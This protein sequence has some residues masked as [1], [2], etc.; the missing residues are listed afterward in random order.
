VAID[1]IRLATV[2]RDPRLVVAPTSAIRRGREHADDL[3]RRAEAL[4]DHVECDEA[5]ADDDVDSATDARV[6]TLAESAITDAISMRASDI[7]V[8]P[9]EDDTQVRD[10]I[11]GVLQQATTVPRAAT[12]ALLSRFELM[13]G[14]DIAQRRGPRDRHARIRSTEGVVDLRMSTLRGMFGEKLVARLLRKDAEL[15]GHRP[16]GAERPPH[17]RQL[18]HVRP[19]RRRRPRPLHRGAR[20]TCGPTGAPSAAVSCS[21]ADGSAPGARSRRP[22]RHRGDRAVGLEWTVTG[23]AVAPAPVPVL[24]HTATQGSAR[25]SWSPPP[26]RSW[27]PSRRSTIPRSD[28]RSPSSTWWPTSASTAAR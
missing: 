20:P 7:H 10:R 26:N 23:G 27:R 6:V 15:L 4:I 1:D 3:D 25:R 22:C 28:S 14:M 8:E 16:A 9:T 18:S 19:A 12:G 2:S 21:T 11:D 5:P 17:R 24:A 13:A